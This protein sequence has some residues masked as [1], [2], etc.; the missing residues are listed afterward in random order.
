LVKA[1]E[2]DLVAPEERVVLLLTG[3]GLKDVAGAMRT[4]P[5]PPVIAPTLDAVRRVLE[6]A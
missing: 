3:S 1:V 5:E 4:V 6:G 2:R